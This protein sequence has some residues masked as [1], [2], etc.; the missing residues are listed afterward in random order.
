MC[1]NAI[2]C[3]TVG[4]KAPIC[5]AAGNG[6]EREGSEDGS[7]DLS[8]DIGNYF[9]C[10]EPAPR[11]KANRHCRVE[12]PA[13]NMADGIGHGQHRETECQRH[14]HETY[15]QLWKRCRKNSAA[16]AAKN[17]PERTESFSRQPLYHRSNNYSLLNSKNR[18]QIITISGKQV[19][20]FIEHH[21]SQ[22]VIGV[23]PGDL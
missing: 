11:P 18:D 5:L 4:C 16:T 21:R 9:A 12:M 7:N 2:G 14:P 22:L 19:S 23:E 10:F 20:A 13:R 6:I 1:A 3:K 17:Q 8:G 15:S